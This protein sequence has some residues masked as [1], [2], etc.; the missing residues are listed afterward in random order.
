MLFQIQLNWDQV[1]D[2]VSEESCSL[3]FKESYAKELCFDKED[4][5]SSGL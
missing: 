2:V 3:N 5:M 4:V 1:L